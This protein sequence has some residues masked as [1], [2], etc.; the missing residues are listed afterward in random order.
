MHDKV[1]CLPEIAPP[2]DAATLMKIAQQQMAAGQTEVQKAA[3]RKTTSPCLGCH[4]QFDPFGLALESYDGIGRYRTMDEAGTAIDPSIDLSA[5]MDYGLGA[6]ATGIVDLAQQ[7]KASGKFATCLASQIMTYAANQV[8]DANDC[9]AQAVG[10]ALTPG[11]D[12]FTDMVR[13]IALSPT[14]RTRSTSGAMP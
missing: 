4:A 6:K 12:K 8:L 3:Y 7:I 13:G 14:F 2:E 5:F 9:G 10:Q 1:L 11:S